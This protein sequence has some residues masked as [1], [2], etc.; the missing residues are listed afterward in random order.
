MTGLDHMPPLPS[1]G[2]PPSECTPPNPWKLRVSPEQQRL[3]EDVSAKAEIKG[4]DGM[5]GRY[6]EYEQRDGGRNARGV[7][8]SKDPQKRGKF[9]HA[10]YITGG[11]KIGRLLKPE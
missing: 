2:M 9:M 4:K 1:S 10:G 5:Q 6:E 8:K 3:K 11:E 7:I